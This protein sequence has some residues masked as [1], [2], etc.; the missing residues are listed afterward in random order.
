MTLGKNKIIFFSILVIFISSY[1]LF[2]QSYTVAQ[3]KKVTEIIDNN[4]PKHHETVGNCGIGQPYTP[5][6]VTAED[7]INSTTI[8]SDAFSN[9]Y[10]KLNVILDS[11]SSSDKFNNT[12]LLF[13]QDG[14][15]IVIDVGCKSG[16]SFIFA[17]WKNPDKIQYNYTLEIFSSNNTLI[18]KTSNLTNSTEGNLN[19]YIGTLTE[20]GRYF[21]LTVDEPQNF[22]I[23]DSLR[24]V[25]IDLFNNIPIKQFNENL[26][27]PL[28][29]DYPNN[30]LINS[31]TGISNQ[32]HKNRVYIYKNSSGDD[33]TMFYPNFV[34]PKNPITSLETGKIFFV[35]INYTHIE[36]TYAK[37]TVK[38][39]NQIISEI[40]IVK[41][42]QTSHKNKDTNTPE[43]K[44]YYFLPYN[45]PPQIQNLYSN[46]FRY[47]DN[48]NASNMN[49]NL[50]IA[51]APDSE[52]SIYYMT[53]VNVSNS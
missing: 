12:E 51:F 44:R 39:D 19:A 16:I 32:E 2:S 18:K 31:F 27:D 23:R 46:Y 37:I 53:K 33:P 35:D 48:T 22:T 14:D 26:T 15:S 40:P 42:D 28:T 4:N 20:A 38:D 10:T 17:N 11:G 30:V 34:Y 36:G 24:N 7:K 8:I 13:S 6:A 3:S 1:F 45:I 9:G 49:G 41:L 47:D 43:I 5:V 52:T 29:F 21:K 50:T 25:W